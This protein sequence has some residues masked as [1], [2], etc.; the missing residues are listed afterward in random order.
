MAPVGQPRAAVAVALLALLATACN[1][2]GGDDEPP[3]TV[4]PPPTQPPSRAGASIDGVLTIGAVLPLTGELAHFGPGMQAAV[5]LAVDEV[6][7][8]GGVLGKPVELVVE[9]SASSADGAAQA[10]QR[11]IDTSEADAL[12]GPASSLELAPAV[13]E[14]SQEA[15]RVVCSPTA[16]APR[17]TARDGKGLFFAMTPNRRGEMEVVAARLRAD[18]RTRVAVVR[19]DDPDAA[20]LFPLLGGP[21]VADVTVEPGREEADAEVAEEAAATV[22]DAAPDAVVLLLAPGEAAPVLRAML[23]AGL[24]PST[25]NPGVAVFV[26]DTLASE[27]L[28]EA[29]NPDNPAVLSGV[30]GVRP[31]VTRD[32]A[33][34]FDQ[35]LRARF[36]LDDVDLAAHAYD[37]TTLVTAAAQ[38][39]GSDDPVAMAARMVDLTRGG[40]GVLGVELNAAGEPATG[41]FQRF[42]FDPAGHIRVL[43]DVTVAVPPG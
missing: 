11:L 5:E 6:N 4:P 37:C 41:A 26:L 39:A 17:L 25:G 15:E 24:L 12:V 1:P 20:A 9:D 22:A 29:V 42:E 28:V 36:G 19:R 2:F 13:L 34:A 18:G 31:R 21:V 33:V 8:A 38:A 43:E 23:D 27:D 3:T 7:D 40:R 16:S 30:Q 35:Q 10:A 14:R 32:A